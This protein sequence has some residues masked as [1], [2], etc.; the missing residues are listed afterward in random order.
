MVMLS[1]IKGCAV[2]AMEGYQVQVEVDVSSGLPAFDIVGLPDASVRESKERVRTAIR[3]AGFEFPSKRITVN[4][5]P[6]DRKKEG[7]I[8]DLP[9]AIGI[10]SATE[11]IKDSE[12]LRGSCFVGELSLEGVIRSV[13]GVLVMA[14][15]LTSEIKHFFVPKENSREAA[16][17]SI[18]ANVYGASSLQD[19][20]TALNGEKILEPVVV[21]MN[22]I[23]MEEQL[24]DLPDMKDVRGQAGAK[25]AMEVAAAGGHNMLFIGS[26]G[27][28]KT[29]LAR[30]MPSILPPFTQQESLLVTKIY[31]VAG[32]LPAGQGLLTQRPFRSPHHSAS[33]ASI[34]GGGR[35]P[36]P[37]EVSL[38]TGGVLFLDEMPEF[39]REVLEALRQ[40]LEDRKVT[41]SRVSGH[42]DFPAGFQLI[43]AMNPCPCGHYGDA[44]KECTCTPLQIGRYFSRISGPLLDRIDL[45]IDVPRVEYQ[46][47]A[48]QKEGESSAQIRA[49]V[50]KARNI[51]LERFAKDG[52]CCNAEME[53]K[54]IVAYCDMTDV[55]EKILQEA[56]RVLGL[57]ARGYDRILKV[58]RTIAD[59]SGES[60]IDMEH[61]A[62]AIQYRR[63]DRK[64][65]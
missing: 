4:L 6:A 5:A 11:Q 37:G 9:I 3:N 63:L 15:D 40:P 1:I 35:I 64:E 58:A 48:D 26:P 7:A 55:A 2:F 20:V 47:I 16:I 27:S 60:L 21:D 57:S 65:M 46:E 43:G 36:S 30:R 44:V 13:S 17:G 18:S 41:V 61:I 32:V 22:E 28:G 8:F 29:M 24:R 10:L 53:R 45:H 51:Q 56:F 39:K 62:E 49:R 19:V 52:I 31:S 25:R 50:I 14:A 38:A 59:L 34:I 12:L 33:G 42:A 23:F 54:H